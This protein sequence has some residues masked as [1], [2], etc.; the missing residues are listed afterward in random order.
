MR[1]P[2]HTR[3]ISAMD[4]ADFDDREFK[5]KVEWPDGSIGYPWVVAFVDRTSHKTIGYAVGKSENADVTEAAIVDTCA[6]NYRP[7]KVACDN[8]GAFSSHRIMGAQSPLFRKK[9]TRTEDWDAPGVL[10]ILGIAATNKGIG[11]KTSNR[12]ENVGP[13]LCHVDN[14]PAFYRAQ[15]SGPNDPENCQPR[16][17]PLDCF[18]EV[19]EDAIQDLNAAMQNRVKGLL[20]GESRAQAFERLLGDAAKRIVTPFMRRRLGMIWKIK[21]VQ[22]N[23][24]I[25]FDGGLLGDHTTQINMLRHRGKKVLVG[26]NPENFDE[27]AMACYWGN[28]AKRGS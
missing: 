28:K 21:T 5:V 23:G 7:I 2:Q 8:G 27:P 14:H 17:V 1:M 12:Q 11:A 18:E 3:G 6:T 4:I 15:R 25:H 26:F 10:T 22:P 19:L 20:K 24:R 16:A 9:Q 13:H